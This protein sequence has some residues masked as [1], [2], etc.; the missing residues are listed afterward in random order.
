MSSLISK[1]S[2]TINASPEKLWDALTNPEIVKQYFF[3]T[4]QQSDW[5]VGSDITW[6]GEWEGK[7]YKDK[8]KILDVV[9]G[10][11]L[12]Y[13]Y[14]SSMMGEEDRPENY[15]TVTFDLSGNGNTTDI[16]ITQDNNKSEESR[17]HSEQNWKMI[18]DEL[19]KLL[20]SDSK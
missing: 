20:E 19:K 7:Q 4:N 12:Q 5:K 15:R 11:R 8:G 17:A 14:F 1:A 10:K 18:L 3:G 9:P 6:T 13:T 2:T 16:T